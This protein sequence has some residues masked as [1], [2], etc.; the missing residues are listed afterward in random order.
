MLFV[1]YALT[2]Y[3]VFRVNPV[4]ELVNTP[5]PVPSFVQLPLVVGLADSLQHTPL[6]V[7]GAPPSD[8]T[9]PPLKALFGVIAYGVVVVTEGGMADV[10]KALSSP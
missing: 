10:V 1:A 2:W 8:V 9:F 5:A 3:E 6:A 7:T 4:I